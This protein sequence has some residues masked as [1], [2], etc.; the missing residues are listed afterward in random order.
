MKSTAS[1][2][3][4]PGCNKRSALCRPIRSRT[5]CP[6]C[7]HSA[8]EAGG[9]LKIVLGGI[10]LLSPLT[11]IGQYAYHLGCGLQKQ[12]GF[13]VD[14]FYATRFSSEMVQKAPAAAG[15]LQ[16]VARKVVP[17]AY[18]LRRAFRQHRFD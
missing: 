17:H 16:V 15:K 8:S 7:W 14:F 10:A 2:E 12:P 3:T 6:G 1:A 11:G 9:D 4:P 18:A 13:D 5:P